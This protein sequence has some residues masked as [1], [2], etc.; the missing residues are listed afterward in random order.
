MKDYLESLQKNAEYIKSKIKIIPEVGLILGSGLG[1]F[2]EELTDC[3]SI[4]YSELI[5]FPK[6]TVDGHSG[7][8]IFTKV[9]DVP[10]VIMQGRVHYYEGYKM[11]EV[12]KPIRLMKL[13]G[14]EKLI[15]TNAAGGI[16][17]KFKPGDLMMITSQISTFVPSPLIGKNIEEFG[18][19]FPDMSNV[20]SKRLQEIIETSARS[21]HIKIKKGVYIQT[22][23]PQYE[24][25]EE[26]KMF[27]LLGADAVGMSTACEAIAA[28]HCGMEVC[29]I[30]CITNKAAGISTTPLSHNEVKESADKA[31]ENFKKLINSIFKNI[32]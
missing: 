19:R 6:S 7:R 27:K 2:A 4:Y 31:A 10:T 3:K 11:N 12:V 1:S 20:Y 30:S 21:E 13:L 15:I 9:Q 29:G 25:P 17:K 26:V 24:T 14:A 28:V 8:F 18:A 22:T 32:K 16:N 23:G 5:D